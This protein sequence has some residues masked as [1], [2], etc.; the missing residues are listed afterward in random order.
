MERKTRIVV[1]HVKELIYTGIFVCLGIAL[2]LLLIFM[3]L[4]QKDKKNEVPTS[5]RYVAGIYSTSILLNGNT[6]DVEVAVDNNRINSIQFVNLSESMTAMYPLLQPALD[7][8]AQ[9]VYETQSL[10]N[11]NYPDDNKYTS[12]LILEAIETSLEKAAAVE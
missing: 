4:P 7:N 10:E 8:I 2:I 3:F 5:S 9:Q 11:I 12:S 1:L 6:I